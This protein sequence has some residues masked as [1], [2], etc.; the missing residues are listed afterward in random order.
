MDT[1]Y[2]VVKA[3][4]RGWGRARRGQGGGGWGGGGVK[5]ALHL[6][7]QNEAQLSSVTLGAKSAVFNPRPAQSSQGHPHR[8]GEGQ[9]RRQL[10][11]GSG[12]RNGGAPVGDMLVQEATRH[13]PLAEHWEP[14]WLRLTAGRVLGPSHAEDCACPPLSCPTLFIPFW[15][16]SLSFKSKFRYLE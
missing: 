5:K 4:G 7:N 12:A 13:S 16:I 8:E 11:G 14:T 3:W 6:E 9:K 15:S 1:A 2:S 10:G